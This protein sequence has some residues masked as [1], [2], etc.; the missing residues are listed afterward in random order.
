MEDRETIAKGFFLL[1]LVIWNLLC[2]FWVVEIPIWVVGILS[3]DGGT[4]AREGG[5]GVWRIHRSSV[6]APAVA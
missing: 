5:A 2:H 6:A 1:L 3:R 4:R